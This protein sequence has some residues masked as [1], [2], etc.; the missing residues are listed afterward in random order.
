MRQTKQVTPK[1]QIH[2]IRR[3]HHKDVFE[4]EIGLPM[5]EGWFKRVKFVA[6]N[7]EQHVVAD[8]PHS[9][10]DDVYAYF[11]GEVGLEYSALYYYYFSY[12]CNGE[13]RAYKDADNNGYRVNYRECFKLSV[14]FEVADWG[15]DE[16]FIHIFVDRYRRGS[17]E[18]LVEFGKRTINKWDEPPVL[19][20]NAKGLWNADFYGGDLLGIIQT[21]D[22]ID[23]LGVSNIYLSPICESETNHRYDTGDYR[24]IDPYAGTREHLKLL[25][26]EAHKRGMRVILDGVFNHTG[27]NSLY[28][29]KD[30]EY[31]TVGAYQSTESP[32]FHFYESYIDDNGNIQFKCWW[33]FENMPVCKTY[34]E[35]W[36]N[37]ICGE[38]GII[39]DWFSL[40][41]DGIRLDV[42]DELTDYMIFCILEAVKRNKPDGILWAEVWENPMRKYGKDG[43]KRRYL[44]AGIGFHATMNYPLSE[45]L[46]KYFKFKDTGALGQKIDEI[47]TEY[48]EATIHA[49]LNSTGTHDISRIINIMGIDDWSIFSGDEWIWDLSGRIKN[50]LKFL[51]EFR[52]TREQ[53]LL[54]RARYLAE[55]AVLTFFPGNVTIFYGDDVGMQGLGN[56]M[57]RSPYPWGR[58]DK[59]VLKFVR[60]VLK[61]KNS[62]KEYKKS[63]CNIIAIRGDYFCFER[64]ISGKRLV[65]AISRENRVVNF[66]DPYKE[67]KKTLLFKHG[68]GTTENTLGAYGVIVYEVEL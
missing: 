54:G 65:V 58:R 39:D 22:Y 11:V 42:A 15:Q 5:S 63:K 12:E 45:A 16:S 27:S 4:V 37:F 29:N 23:R 21:L 9:R 57:V 25:C 59:K 52:L 19:G 24:K 1:Y 10:N 46:I 33:D 53:Y 49:E 28:F 55:L 43:Q 36:I 35:G 44:S 60:S 64:V 18:E 56:L 34:Y 66:D 13:K 48:P 7:G 68:K 67:S 8:L 2:L 31:D 50:N 32:Y 14:G 30:G 62:K 40:G 6:F 26:S 38:G 41:I 61:V 3:R 17:K 47:F 20:P 51:S